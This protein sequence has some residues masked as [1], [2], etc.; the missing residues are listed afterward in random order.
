LGAVSLALEIDAPTALDV[1]R[2][3][4]YGQDR[5]VDDV[6]ADLLAGRLTAEDLRRVTS[7]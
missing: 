2:A 7:G 6:A 4:A 3:A 1:M 5:P